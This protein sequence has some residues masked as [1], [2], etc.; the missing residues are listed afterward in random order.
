[1]VIG[2]GQNN[3]L[4]PSTFEIGNEYKKF[5][6]VFYT[7]YTDAGTEVSAQESEVGHYYYSGISATSTTSNLPTSEGS[8]WTQEFFFPCEYG[9]SVS[10]ENYYYKTSLGDGY[11]SFLSKSEN[12]LVAKFE[13]QFEKRSDKESMCA[14]HLLEDSF[15]K[16]NKPTGGYTGIYWEPFYPYDNKKEF[17][18]EEISHSIQYPNVNSYNT[19]FYDETSSITD[20]QSLY[21]PFKNT[22]GFFEIGKNYSKHDIVFASG[23]LYNIST[24]GWYYYTGDSESTASSDNGP[25]GE[26][27]MWTKNEFYFDVNDGITIN[28]SPRFFKQNFSNQFFKRVEDGINKKL[29]ELDFSFR[30]RSDKESKAMAH[31]LIN[32]YG[33]NQFYFTP[34]FPYNEKK[35]FICPSWSHT[36]IYKNNN[37]ISVKFIEHPINYLAKRTEFL[38][39]ITIDPYIPR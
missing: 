1:M 11:Y 34:P 29:L 28:Q 36:P 6:V 31:F 27:S 21:I 38:N 32:K 35:V 10:F 3:I 5:D 9:S 13:T 8:P 16:G 22:N 23:S 18:I 17:Y 2:S 33:R 26:N 14:V 30:G 12:S 7:G 25:I 19:T 4:T 20:W 15:N 24:S 37:D 39:L